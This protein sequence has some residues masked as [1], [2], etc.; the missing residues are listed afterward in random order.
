MYIYIY[1]YRYT[2]F[3]PSPRSP[4]ADHPSPGVQIRLNKISF[5][6]KA[7]LCESIIRLLPPPTCIALTIAILLHVHC[8][9]Y[10]APPIPLVYA[11]HHTILGLA[12]SCKGQLTARMSYTIQYW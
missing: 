6:F 1:I 2:P 12:M 11:I 9:L 3:C 4:F 7:L 8:A 5:Y 10:D